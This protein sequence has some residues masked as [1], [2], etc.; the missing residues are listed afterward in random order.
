M[1]TSVFNAAMIIGWLLALAGG[2]ILSPGAG[3]VGAGLLLIALVLLSVRLAGGL[4]TPDTPAAQRP[5]SRDTN[6]IEGAA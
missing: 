5:G 4:Y 2:V 1:Q 6:R 3:L